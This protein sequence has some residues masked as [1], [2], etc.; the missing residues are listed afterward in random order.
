MGAQTVFTTVIYCALVFPLARWSGSPAFLAAAAA[1]PVAPVAAPV[2]AVPAIAPAPAPVH[3]PVP[4]PKPLTLH[5][6]VVSSLRA[7]GHYGAI[8]GLIDS[9]PTANTIVKTGVTLFAPNDNAFSNV[10]M[11]STDYLLTL[12]GYHATPKVYS[13]Q[14]LLTLTDGTKVPTSAP[15]VDIVVTSN[16]QDSYKLDDSLI[17]DKDIFVDSTVAV[18][19]IDSILN[20]AKY[21]KGAVAPEAAPAPVNPISPIIS[22]PPAPPVSDTPVPPGDSSDGP[23][24]EPSAP[25]TAK[26]PNA[27][28]VTSMSLLSSVVMAF[29]VCLSM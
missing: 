14:G 9:L 6:K 27:A 2:A 24:M 21:N 26:L 5:E 25:Q 23:S 11:N 12:L 22:S 15:N 28:S 13:Y 19:G 1:V 8:A 7:A 29:L 17:V 10:P 20:T 3:A 18:H 4:A 16:V